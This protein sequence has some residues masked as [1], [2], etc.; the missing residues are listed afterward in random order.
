MMVE[1]GDAYSMGML[2][3]RYYYG[4][5]VEQDYA[6]A[7]KWYQK[8][9]E[10]G[11]ELARYNLAGCYEGGRGV[12]KDSTKALQWYKKAAASGLWEAKRAVRRLLIE[13]NYPDRDLVAYL[14]TYYI[15]GESLVSR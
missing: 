3:D 5:D 14:L 11:I 12:E 2:G 9:A 15:E 4:N 7:A 1:R 6:K 10:Q 13:D 8:A